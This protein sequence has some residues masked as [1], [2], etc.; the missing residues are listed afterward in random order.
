MVA[1]TCP[2]GGD[3]VRELAIAAGIGDGARTETEGD[4]AAPS[5][6]HTHE[7]VEGKYRGVPATLVTPAVKD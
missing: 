5:A 4:C 2:Q 6:S 3:E 1:A 7:M